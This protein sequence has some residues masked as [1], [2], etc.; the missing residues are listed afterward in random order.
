MLT[1]ALALVLTALVQQ[2][3]AAPV[4]IPIL[5][6]GLGSCAA[7]FVV[8]DAQ[9][10]PVYGAAIHVRVRYGVLGVKRADLE[11]GT[12]SNGQARIE[13]LPAKAKPLAYD[14]QKDGRKATA[15]QNVADRC[16]AK[17]DIELK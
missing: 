12:N 4:E 5:K 6:A 10:V 14:I 9:G 13:G 16:E 3:P 2:P 1:A 15:A 8:K 7:D 17:F 11:V